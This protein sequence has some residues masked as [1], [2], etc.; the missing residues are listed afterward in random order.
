MVRLLGD[1]L[2]VPRGGGRAVVR[3]T[4][5]LLARRL[6]IC[7]WC[8]DGGG[9]VSSV[10]VCVRVSEVSVRAGGD[11]ERWRC[12]TVWQQLGLPPWLSSELLEDLWKTVPMSM[13]RVSELILAAAAPSSHASEDTAAASSAASSSHASEGTP[14]EQFPSRAVKRSREILLS[15]HRHAI[16]CEASR[17]KETT[18]AWRNFSLQHI[19]RVVAKI[20]FQKLGRTEQLDYG[21]SAREPN[22]APST[23]HR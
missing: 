9:S 15:E 22:L 11:G 10:V 17:L 3:P 2:H 1:A 8:G 19:M 16:R 18:A 21:A 7:G 12:R 23:A 5:L 6:R 4:L 14:K 20:K 13:V